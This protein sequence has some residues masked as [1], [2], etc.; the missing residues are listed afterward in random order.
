MQ[1][2]KWL[3]GIC[4][5]A[6]SAILSFA[7]FAFLGQSRASAMASITVLWNLILSA[8][9]LKERATVVDGLIALI[10]A[11]GAVIT[12]VFGAEGS[13]ALPE[14]NIYSV[15]EVLSRPIV[16]QAAIVVIIIYFTSY[17][18]IRWISKKG[19]ERTPVQL[20][21]EIYLRCLLADLHCG[22]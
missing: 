13:G 5:M 18:T 17:F 12:V 22:E 11:V 20:R 10:I 21:T 3:L 7:V 1:Q 19:K 9:F 8:I 16:W 2:K 6:L 14:T 15:I 4:C